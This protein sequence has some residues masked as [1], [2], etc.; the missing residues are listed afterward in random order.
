M[1]DKTQHFQPFWDFCHFGMGLFTYYVNRETGGGGY[2]F[3]DKSDFI[4]PVTLEDKQE[5]AHNALHFLAL[6]RIPW[7]KEWHQ[8]QE[9]QSA[10][11]LSW[12]FQ[13][14]MRIWEWLKKRI[15]LEHGDFKIKFAPYI[16]NL[17]WKSI[18]WACRIILGPPKHVLRLVPSPDAIA[19]A[20]NVM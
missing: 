17:F 14:D 1:F 6:P 19:K 10:H 4:L 11:F 18:Q 7:S 16:W 20:F 5:I 8:C 12:F 13:N 2:Y 9:L 3:R 15:S